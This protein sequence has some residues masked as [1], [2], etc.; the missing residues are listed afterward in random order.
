M[1]K[2]GPV[3]WIS[4]VYNGKRYRQSSGTASKKLAQKIEH[5]VRGEVVEGKWFE[6]LPG[7]DKSFREMMEK[8]MAEHS[9]MN[10]TPKSHNRDKSLRDHLLSFFEHLPLT[11][12]SPKLI[13][14]Y[15]SQRRQNGAAPQTINNELSLMSHVFSLAI[16][17][18][19]WLRENPVRKVSK[20]RV[21]NQM[22][23]WLTLEDEKNLLAFSP[24]MDARDHCLRG[25]HRSPS[26]RN[27][28]PAMAPGGHVQKDRRHLRAEK[29]REG[30]LT[31]Q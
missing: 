16:K 28:R 18:W 30:Y 21:N 20:E 19:E 23:R 25:E 11:E 27:P 31:P 4:F 1:F 29:Q 7:E 6:K 17:E 12:I 14:D 5:K 8:Y 13:Y 3:W 10:K 24:P 9:A 26:R 22:E 15:K 2:R